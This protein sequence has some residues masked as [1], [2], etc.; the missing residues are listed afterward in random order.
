[1]Q[2]S[3]PATYLYVDHNILPLQFLQH[4]IA[5]IFTLYNYNS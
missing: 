5:T 3:K 1:M 4:M 2:F